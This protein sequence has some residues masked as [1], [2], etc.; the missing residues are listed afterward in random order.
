MEEHTH[1]HKH[2]WKLKFV[3]HYNI[4]T[5]LIKVFTF[6]Q[7]LRCYVSHVCLPRY[8]ILY[9]GDSMIWSRTWSPHQNQNIYITFRDDRFDGYSV[10]W[11]YVARMDLV[12]HIFRWYIN[13]RMGFCVKITH[14][15][16]IYT[17]H[18]IHKVAHVLLKIL[19]R[20]GVGEGIE[21]T[22]TLN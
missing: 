19:F 15:M 16:N 4:L 20:N 7:H 14:P 21:K 11:P 6:T 9:G 22:L 1:T 2:I 10:F 18:R 5:C 13:H 12:C 3:F 8:T 17:P